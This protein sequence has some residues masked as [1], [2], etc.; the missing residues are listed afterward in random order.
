[1]DNLPSKQDALWRAA[2]QNFLTGLLATMV[3]AALI[4]YGREAMTH[5]PFRTFLWLMGGYFMLC[6]LYLSFQRLRFRTKKRDEA[7]S[8]AFR[9]LLE[10]SE[11]FHKSYRVLAANDPEHTKRPLNHTSWPASGSDQP[12]SYT[13]VSLCCLSSHFTWFLA[14]AK[15]SFNEMAWKEWV[16]LFNLPEDSTLMVDLLVALERFQ[17]VLESKIELAEESK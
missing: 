3:G 17:R 9:M 11:F 4:S 15:V 6:G 16:E 12:W 7:R 1:M 2:T 10:E 5:E 13:N 14:A 8:L